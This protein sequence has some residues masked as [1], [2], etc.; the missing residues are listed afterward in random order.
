LRPLPDKFIRNRNI[1]TML[2]ELNAGASWMSQ[3]DWCLRYTDK[4]NDPHCT[5]DQ[6][7][8]LIGTVKDPPITMEFLHHPDTVIVFPLCWQ[9]CLFGSTRKFDKS[10]DRADP[11]DLQTLRT[12]QKQNVNRF[13]VSPVAI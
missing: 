10:Y 12:Y 8:F 6:P 3:L 5:T 11:R 9:A 2:E 13:V 1:S 4:E 7:V